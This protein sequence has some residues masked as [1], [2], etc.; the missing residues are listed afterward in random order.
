MFIVLQWNPTPQHGLEILNRVLMKN[1]V[2]VI[3]GLIFVL[4]PA[5]NAQQQLTILK[6]VYTGGDVQKDVTPFLSK[7]VRDGQL[8][9]DV[10]NQ[11][12]GGD[13]AFG[14]S[15]A[16]T[17]VYR[18][19][20]GDFSL[21]AHEGEKLSIPSPKAIRVSNANQETSKQ[22]A[23]TN[24]EQS[25]PAEIKQPT[26][27]RAAPDGIF[28]LLKRT[29]VSTDSGIVGLPPGTRVERISE[30]DGKLKVKFGEQEFEIEKSLLTN[31]LDIAGGMASQDA[32]TQH[33]LFVK[34][35]EDQKKL[36]AKS[37]ASEKAKE[38]HIEIN[39]VVS[40]GVLADLLTKR[41]TEAVADR[42][43]SN[44]LGGNVYRPDDGLYYERSGNTAFIQGVNGGVEG[45]QLA[46]K[47]YPD[48]TYTFTD[49]QGASRTVEKWVAV[50]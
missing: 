38:M 27:H 41:Y 16:L 3:I 9:F 30:S 33:A 37:K 5:L 49:T 29:S 35:Q 46:I 31:D 19:A 26:T 20:S 39:Q 1:V 47:A 44:G 10:G 42:A 18:T 2:A 48:G 4:S 13:P 24:S 32:Q 23:P 6:A 28:F 45:K 22:N 34:G 25:T 8:L 17:V 36:A 50:Q 11:S 21:T 14:K 15:K 40:G 43:A 7:A 12:L